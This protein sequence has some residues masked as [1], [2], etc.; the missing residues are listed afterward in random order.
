MESN[1]P[2]ICTRLSRELQG[3]TITAA[4]LPAAWANQKASL[5]DDHEGVHMKCVVCDEGDDYPEL[6]REGPFICLGCSRIIGQ[7]R[8][9][10][11]VADLRD[12]EFSQ[13]KAS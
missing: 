11:T 10:E 7:P 4:A 8:S 9:A 3:I 12:R 13:S 5:L 6:E 2:A 1:R